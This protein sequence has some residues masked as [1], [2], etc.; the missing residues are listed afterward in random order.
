MRLKT[1]GL[2]ALCTGAAL[3]L[4]ASARDVRAE[5]SSAEVVKIWPGAPPG[6]ADWTG[7]EVDQPLKIPGQ[8][9]IHMVTNVTVP[10]L[11]VYR[12]A[13]GKAN[14][15][16]IIVCPGGGFQN[17]AITHEGEMVAQW[18]ADR[19]YTAFILKYRV[20]TTGTFHIPPDIRHHPERFDDMAQKMESGRQLA[21]VDATQ[22]VRL[23]RANA[24]RYGVAPDR[25]GFMGFSAGAITTMGVA[26]NASPADRP[27]FGAP[28]Y[29]AMPDQVPPKD[30]PPLFIAAAQD[31]NAVPVTKSVEIFS[32]WTAADLPA[33]LHVYEHGGHGFGM[34]QHKTTS[35]SWTSAFEAW[36]K[37]HGWAGG[38]ATVQPGR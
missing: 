38:G 5:T 9:A 19:G 13:A 2:V 25:I 23:L 18:L 8:P 26:M 6:T 35:D 29:G 3:L 20:R 28:I 17:L 7:P 11:T 32:R 12:P 27:N 14:G 15:T 31:D 34:L 16:A 30:G 1:S 22:A 24:D 21:L 36:A 33:E 37:A 10:T 4:G